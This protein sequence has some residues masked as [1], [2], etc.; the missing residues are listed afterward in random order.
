[1]IESKM[2][3]R[4]IDVWLLGRV[5]DRIDDGS[6]LDRLS[7]RY[8]ALKPCVLKSSNNEILEWCALDGLE[9]E[10]VLFDLMII[11]GRRSQSPRLR[12][13]SFLLWVGGLNRPVFG[14]N[15]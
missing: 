3:W 5:G 1:M 9:S 10:V 6:T 8:D 13:S 7:L 4:W 2:V 11:I 15:R 14:K 12:Q